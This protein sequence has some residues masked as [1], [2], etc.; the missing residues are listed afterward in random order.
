VPS[1]QGLIRPHLFVN[2]L[3]RTKLQRCIRKS[4]QLHWWYTESASE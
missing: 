4:R 3:L 1:F 2:N